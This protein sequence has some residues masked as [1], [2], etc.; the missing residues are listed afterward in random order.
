MG[1]SGNTFW[2]RLHL[3]QAK[4]YFFWTE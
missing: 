2:L 3:W 1:L 4:L